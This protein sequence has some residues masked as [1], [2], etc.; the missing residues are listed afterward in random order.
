MKPFPRRAAVAVLAPLCLVVG[1]PGGTALAAGSPSRPE[2]RTQVIRLVNQQRAAAGCGKR[3]AAD[4]RLTKSAQ[5]H[6]TDMAERNYFSHVSK[7]GRTWVQRIRHAGYPEPGGENIG[8]GFD[9]AAGVVRAWMRSPSHRRNVL[10]C[11][12]RK[13]GVGYDGD[14]G[15]WVQDFGY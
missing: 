7:D 2:L 6:A 12:F 10:T 4:S 8:V 14:G 9:T 5:G 3:V 1:A 11:S 13:I 15:Y